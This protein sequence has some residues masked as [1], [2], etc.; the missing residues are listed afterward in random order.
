MSAFTY[1][2]HCLAQLRKKRLTAEKPA[3]RSRASN[4]R[5]LLIALID[6]I[7]QMSAL[8]FKFADMPAPIL[9]QWIVWANSHD[10]AQTLEPRFDSAT[11]EMVVASQECDRAGNWS[12]VEARHKTPRAL[13][14]WAGY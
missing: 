2:T 11:G 13:R 14:D 10:W 7:K 1:S 3:P 12:A 4:E 6:G 8:D 9:A 5:F